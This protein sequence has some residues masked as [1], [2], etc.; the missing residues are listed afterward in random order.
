MNCVTKNDSLGRY[1]KETFREKTWKRARECD[2]KLIFLLEVYTIT[3][4][5]KGQFCKQGV[6]STFNMKSVL[7]KL[8]ADGDLRLDFE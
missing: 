4:S 3:E 8:S 6:H 7:L 5:Q 2:Y 1:E